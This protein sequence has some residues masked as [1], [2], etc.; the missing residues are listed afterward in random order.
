L[1]A[2]PLKN[3]GDMRTNADRMKQG[4]LPYV[5]KN[6]QYE[7][8]QFHHSRQDGRG[9]LF[10]TSKS[11]HLERNDQNG[12]QAVHPYSPQQ[13]PY[14]PVDRPSFKTDKETYWKDRL[15]QLQGK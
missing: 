12:R 9:A 15:N 6:G 4:R 14:Y 1:K 7:Q 8:I 10:E 5:L 3:D 2:Q 11:T 13:H